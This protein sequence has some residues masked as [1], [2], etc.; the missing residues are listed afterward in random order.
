MLF[1]GKINRALDFLREKNKDQKKRDKDY[2]TYANELEK[3]DLL[4]MIL[5][6]LIVIVPVAL[7]VLLAIAAIGYFFMV[8]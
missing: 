8:R 3:G 7:V 6:A 5:A 2:S 4:A 1:N